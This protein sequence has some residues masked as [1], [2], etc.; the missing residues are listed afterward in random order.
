MGRLTMLEEANLLEKVFAVHGVAGGV[1]PPPA[2]FQTA[3]LRVYRLWRGEGV[4]VSRV[5][6]MVDELDEALTTACN[7]EVLCRFAR[8]PLRVEIPRLDPQPLLLVDVLDNLTQQPPALDVQSHLLT[9]VGEAC[10][11]KAET[12][13]LDLANP[14][15]P[16]I[17]VAGTTGSGKSN[18]LLSMV[19]SLTSLYSP[20][21]VALVLLD[22]KGIDFAP[23]AELP[24]L[25]TPLVSDPVESV[26]V[27]RLAVAEL[28]RRK[29]QVKLTAEGKLPTNLPRLVVVIDEL[30]ELAEVAGT[31]VEANIK[32]LL[33]IG[34]GVGVHVMA[35]TQKPLASVI[36]SLVKANFPVRMVGKVASSEDAKVAAG[37]PGTGAERLPGKGS[38]LLVQGG[39]MQRMQA[40]LLPY[41]DLQAQAKQISHSWR[42]RD[43]LHWRLPSSVTLAQP[44]VIDVQSDVTEAP[45]NLPG[46]TATIAA[47]N[48]PASYPDWLAQMVA[49]YI[50]THQQL[51]SQKAV[52][53]AYQE[54]TGQMLN[55]EAIKAAIA[56]G[57][58]SVDSNG[59]T[60]A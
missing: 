17:L 29:Q 10:R 2:S 31:Q 44:G 60:Q 45:S 43:V 12:L 19:T 52:Q 54:E 3:S 14:N 20:T 57:Q 38:F 5:L 27:L 55:W 49:D 26:R 9:V 21:Q 16:H 4:T 8:T 18:L 7:R 42:S 37:I 59:V 25:A 33:Q 23:L 36:G 46:V 39:T 35:A 22:P 47:P 53:R 41:P 1:L 24:H 51:P 50:R 13:L 48:K 15:S 34:R 11:Q 28:E 56:Q 6:A 40:Y 30:A 58:Q 32:R